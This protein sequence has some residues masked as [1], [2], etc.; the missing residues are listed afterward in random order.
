M[1][2]MSKRPEATPDYEETEM[3]AA[4]DPWHPFFNNQQ[5]DSIGLPKRLSADIKEKSSTRAKVCR[6]PIQNLQYLTNDS[7]LHIIMNKCRSHADDLKRLKRTNS[8]TGEL[9]E[10]L[11]D[12]EICF[13]ES[14]IT[15]SEQENGSDGS[16]RAGSDDKDSDDIYPDYTGSDGMN[17]D[18]D[19]EI[20]EFDEE[21]FHAFEGETADMCRMN[22]MPSEKWKLLEESLFACS[23]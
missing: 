22:E 9:L 20:T 17:S 1:S 18:G 13:A 23:S 19:A 7:L 12:R 10:Q 5:K 21:Y 16:K 2:E 6:Y 15:Q 11:R 3:P 14:S 4:P 8:S